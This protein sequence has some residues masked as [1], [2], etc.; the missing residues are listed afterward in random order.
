M[1]MLEDVK[2]ILTEITHQQLKNFQLM[3]ELTKS[4]QKNTKE[5]REMFQETDRRFKETDR[6]FQE[7]DR[8]FQET[9]RKF[10]ETA[11]RFKETDRQFKESDRKSQELEKRMEKSFRQLKGMFTSQWGRLIESLVKGDLIRILNERGIVVE[12]TSERT[13]GSHQG[14]NYE[15][16]IIAHN[17][18]EIV[19]VEVKTTLKPDDVHHFLDKLAKAKVYMERYEHNTLYGAIAYLQADAG[20][21]T[22]AEKKGL[23]VIR[24]TGDSAAIINH[25]TFK[26]KKF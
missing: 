26:P 3:E 25:S 11:R 6:K 7:T 9:D 10:Q 5:I 23:F 21:E 8:K 2:K 1:E 13:K 15:Y 19:I 17:G 16:D 18:E 22:M 4:T 12:D 14:E 20:S 24:A